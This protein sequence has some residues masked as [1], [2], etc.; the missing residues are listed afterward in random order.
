VFETTV[1]ESKRRKLSGVFIS[2]LP[3][4]GVIHAVLGLALVIVS[5]WTVEFPT[6]PPAQAS[7]YRVAEG[8]P[9]PPPPPPMTSKP[10]A[11]QAPKI[12]KPLPAPTEILAP[13]VIPEEIPEVATVAET[14]ETGVVGGVEGG[15]EGG[16]IGGV[17]GGVVGADEGSGAG[18]IVQKLPGAPLKVERDAKLPLVPLSQTYPIYPEKA[19]LNG[20]EGS[21]VVKYTIDKRGRVRE[22]VIIR[23]SRHPILDD[24]AVSAIR[25]WRF[26]PMLEDGQPI[27]VEHE[28]TVFFQLQ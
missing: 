23:P 4:S 8:V 21:L 11:P 26:R 18:G 5:T 16:L 12:E 9:P 20:I 2:T 17:F 22:V 10:R 14:T 3:V 6:M 19:R 25:H 1:V 15:V 7:M 28:L 27:E 24:A 13:S